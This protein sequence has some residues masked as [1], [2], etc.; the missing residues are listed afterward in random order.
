[1]RHGGNSLGTSVIGENG[2]FRSAS[3]GFGGAGRDVGSPGF[4]VVP[5]PG[6]TGI[7]L[8]AGL[9]ALARRSRRC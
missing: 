6:I 1:M 5:E 8:A 3:D 9:A 2:A 7:T 4:A